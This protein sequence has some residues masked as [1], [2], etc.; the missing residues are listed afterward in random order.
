[1]DRELREL[2]AA[3]RDETLSPE[4]LARLESRL[5]GSAEDRGLFLRYQQL[6]GLLES[7]RPEVEIAESDWKSGTLIPFSLSPT[8]RWAA[9]AAA[10]L[11]AGLLVFE[12]ILPSRAVSQPVATL[13]L[14]EDCVWNS[15]S[16]E[17]VIAEGQRLSPGLLWLEQGSAVVRFA[18]GAELV[19]TG[20]TRIDLLS[21]KRVRLSHGEVVVR[22]ENGAEGFTVVT[23]EG[24]LIDLGTE[25]AVRV[26]ESG[27]TELHVHEGEV[28][29][30]ETIFAAG[31]AIRM[32]KREGVEVAINAPR[33]DEAVRN[34]NPRERRDLMLAYE[35]FHVDEGVYQP[36]DLATGKGWNGPWK[37]RTP[38]Q[39]GH[40]AKDSS[41]DMRITHGRMNMAWPVKGGRL[42]M[43]E[44]P[45]GRNFRLR[46]LVK[47]IQF[48]RY[49]ITYVSFLAAESKSDEP[50]HSNSSTQREDFRITFRSSEDYFGESLSLGWSSNRAPRIQQP[51]GVVHR[52]VREVPPDETVFCVAKIIRRA[53]AKDQIYFRF[54]RESDHLDFFEPADWDIESRDADLSAKLDTLLITSIG[55]STR[56]VDEIRIG[57]TWRSVTPISEEASIAEN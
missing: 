5:R 16:K 47:P 48:A 55:Q 22:A 37:L 44:L 54:Y 29:V 49:G 24:D 20:D 53:K 46:E 10:I 40:H 21:A 11:I 23:P 26:E 42:G 39:F 4:A 36:A 41:D 7:N 9:A 12:A 19:L 57:P 25:F 8:W 15:R 45:P 51:D 32:S 1:M 38:E 18:G 52:A 50:S 33:F 30:E 27:T 43:L 17:K 3:A 2:L 14:A 28:A 13:L 31:Q 34:A 35:G 56:F 6:H